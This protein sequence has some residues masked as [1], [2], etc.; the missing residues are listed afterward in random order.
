MDA[1]DRNPSPATGV[2]LGVGFGV[3]VI[4]RNGATSAELIPSIGTDDIWPSTKHAVYFG[5]KDQWDLLQK[6]NPKPQEEPPSSTHLAPAPRY[7][8]ARTDE[9]DAAYLSSLGQAAEHACS[10]LNL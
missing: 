7:V 1:E 2:K 6:N 4:S 8:F 3:A 5:K 9:M 10:T